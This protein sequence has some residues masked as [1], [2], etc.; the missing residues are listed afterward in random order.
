[1]SPDLQHVARMAHAALVGL[2]ATVRREKARNGG[3][4]PLPIVSD[5]MVW[6]ALIASGSITS[7]PTGQPSTVDG[8]ADG[9]EMDI[10]PP[11]VAPSTVDVATAAA[12]L[13]ISVRAVRKRCAA[14]TL[15]S[16]K[17]GTTWLI[18]LEEPHE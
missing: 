14:G 9:T 1:M 3:L 4:T 10:E 7:V 17:I 13:G 11:T 15:A 5:S 2:T 8:S 16:R 6:L 18:E 12:R